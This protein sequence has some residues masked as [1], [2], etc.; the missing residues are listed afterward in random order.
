MT[1]ACRT[2]RFSPSFAR[3]CSVL[4]ALSASSLPAPG[5]RTE[6]RGGT[7]A[8][9]NEPTQTNGTLA[10]WRGFFVDLR[11]AVPLRGMRRTPDQGRTDE[12]GRQERMTMTKGE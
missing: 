7:G 8:K 12:E 2:A 3:S 5:G 10:G 1:R 9:R 6:E 4:T 11:P